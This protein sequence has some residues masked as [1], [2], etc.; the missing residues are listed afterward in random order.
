MS[1]AKTKK[2][3]KDNNKLSK[4]IEKGFNDLEKINKKM[5]K[6]INKI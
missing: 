1:N 3:K 5:S 4:E 2:F 6:E